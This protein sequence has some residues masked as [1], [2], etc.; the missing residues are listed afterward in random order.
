[1]PIGMNSCTREKCCP[2]NDITT[3]SVVIAWDVSAVRPDTK[4]RCSMDKILSFQD[5]VSLTG[6]SKPTLYRM[7]KSGSFVPRVQISVRR[8]GFRQSEVAAW[9]AS[10]EA[11]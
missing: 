5:V 7:L 1:M 9:L 10:R 2:I 4:G 6:L 11:A 8:V 3:R